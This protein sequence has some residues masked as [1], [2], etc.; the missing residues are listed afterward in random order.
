M[1]KNVF[2][3]CCFS[4]RAGS[5]SIFPWTRE[6]SIEAMD[7][8]SEAGMTKVQNFDSLQVLSSISIGDNMDSGSGAGMTKVQN[9]DSLQVLSSISIGD[10]FEKDRRL[11]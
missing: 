10:N 2:S 3:L 7:S 5:R 4:E 1:A 11:E 8:G 6:T 9:F